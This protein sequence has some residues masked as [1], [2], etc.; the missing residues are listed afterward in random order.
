MEIPSYLELLDYQDD[1]IA[2]KAWGEAIKNLSMD[3]VRARVIA[4][5][6]RLLSLLSSSSIQVR[7]TA[8]PMAVTLL[9]EGLLSESELRPLG[10]YYVEALN[11]IGPEDYIKAIFVSVAPELI[12]RGIIGKEDVKAASGTIWG[13]VDR[14][15]AS[16]PQLTKAVEEL[17]RVGALSKRG[18][19]SKGVRILSDDTIIL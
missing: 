7:V 10:K 8:W 12:S 6:A 16:L 4:S 14:L 18:S 17:L 9:K 5:R 3:Y 15:G 1:S 13:L 19:W 11:S 2:I